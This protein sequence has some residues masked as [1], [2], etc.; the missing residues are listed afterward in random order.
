MEGSIY[1]LVIVGLAIPV[2]FYIYQVGWRNKKMRARYELRLMT[3]YLCASFRS[4]YMLK[5]DEIV[6]TQVAIL[7]ILIG[8]GA[9]F[10]RIKPRKQSRRRRSADR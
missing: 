8:L 6:G 4:L 9:A 2:A 5:N 3:A 1:P 10:I 7:S